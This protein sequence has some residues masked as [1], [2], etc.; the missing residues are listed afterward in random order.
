MSKNVLK[1]LG[2]IF[3]PSKTI[4]FMMS[5][6]SKSDSN[7]LLS[8]IIVGFTLLTSL[9]NL[10]LGGDVSFTTSMRLANGSVGFDIVAV[11]EE[12]GL[13]EAFSRLIF[14]KG[15]MSRSKKGSVCV[16]GA[17]TSVVGKAIMDGLFDASIGDPTITFTG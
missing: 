6:N 8:L 15:L 17:S 12:G 1:L 11:V 7:N 2:D 5:T 10:T 13:D 16:F 3:G 4:P 14:L 9:S